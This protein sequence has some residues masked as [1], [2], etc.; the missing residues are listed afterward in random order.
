MSETYTRDVCI[1]KFNQL[2]NNYDISKQIEEGIYQYVIDNVCNS[3]N[4][5]IN[6]NNSYFKRGYLNKCISLYTN[7][8]ESSENKNL[9]KRIMRKEI[10]PYKLAFMTPQ[11]IFPENWTDILAKKEAET[12]FL[13]SNKLLSF[14]DEYVCGRCKQRKCSY[15]LSQSKSADEST[16]VYVTC[17]NCSHKWSFS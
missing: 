3:K 15:H 6:W 5:P 8:S 17:L 4:L 13:Y 9:M 7:L 10:D 11:E 14:T 16:S 1:E 12:E 2:I